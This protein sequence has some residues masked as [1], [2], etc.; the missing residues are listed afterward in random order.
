MAT[1]SYRADHQERGSRGQQW[2]KPQVVPPHPN[3]SG[4]HL[5][6]EPTPGEEALQRAVQQLQADNAELQAEVHH[7]AATLR[8]ALASTPD[9]G[10]SGTLDADE[11]QQQQAAAQRFLE[12]QCQGADHLMLDLE[13]HDHSHLCLHPDGA[14][15][16]SG[17]YDGA[18]SAS[19][20]SSLDGGPA[21]APVY[22]Q[23]PSVSQATLSCSMQHPGSIC[24]SKLSSTLDPGGAACTISLHT[25]ARCTADGTTVRRHLAP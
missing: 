10:Q 22:H 5:I 12:Q 2:A 6:E 3:G 1:L 25:T 21:A 13:Q 4:E 7:L 24:C 19:L 11:L 17:A 9:S 8:A 23:P 14:A 15:W 16:Q 18:S 20:L